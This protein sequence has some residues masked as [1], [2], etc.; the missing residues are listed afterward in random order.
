MKPTSPKM[1][2][3]SS[4][5]LSYVFHHLSPSLIKLSTETFTWN[6]TDK[7]PTFTGIPPP[8][9]YFDYFGGNQDISGC[10]YRW[11]IGEYNCRV[12]EERNIL[13]F[14]WVEDVA[15]AWMNGEYGRVCFEGFMEIGR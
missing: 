11:S 8:C 14:Q 4:F 9:T 12:E 3:K 10:Y 6:K 2:F 15:V 1:I 5:F 13:R 7:T